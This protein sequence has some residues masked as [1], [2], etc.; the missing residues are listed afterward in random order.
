MNVQMYLARNMML[1]AV[2]SIVIIALVTI[3]IVDNVRV[4]L[5]LLKTEATHRHEQRTGNHLLPDRSRRSSARRQA[6]GVG[7]LTQVAKREDL[8]IPP[9]SLGMWL[10]WSLAFLLGVIKLGC[11][12]R[13]NLVNACVLG[14]KYVS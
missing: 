12:W 9:L 4:W 8:S 11:K 5:Q 6:P 13:L 2:L 3:I 1:N 14:M 10:L 7:R